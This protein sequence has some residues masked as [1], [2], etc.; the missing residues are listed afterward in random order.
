MEG[1]LLLRMKTIRALPLSISAPG[2]LTE[3]LKSRMKQKVL[4]SIRRMAKSM[5]LANR[6][7]KYSQSIPINSASSQQSRQ[8]DDRGRLHFCQ[9]AHAHTSLARTAANLP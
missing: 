9:M 2:S 7:A 1:S 5:S 6:K 4:G 3:K 8:A